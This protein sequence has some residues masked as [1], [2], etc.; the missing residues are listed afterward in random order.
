MD[1]GVAVRAE[2]GDGAANCELEGV[3]ACAVAG[4][5]L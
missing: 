4:A 2:D 3:E 5:K 1:H